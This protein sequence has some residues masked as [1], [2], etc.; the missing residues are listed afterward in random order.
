[1]RA[2]PEW[3]IHMAPNRNPLPRS[4]QHHNI[5]NTSQ[6]HQPHRTLPIPWHAN[7]LLRH[8]LAFLKSQ[9]I[10]NHGFVGHF[11]GRIAG[12]HDGVEPSRKSD[13]RALGAEGQ[14]AV[15]AVVV[16]GPR[17]TD[18]AEKRICDTSMNPRREISW[19]IRVD[20]V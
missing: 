19:G 8:R 12:A 1:M 7:L 4:D 2:S 11:V 10:F 15:F 20:R 9:G 13:D 18:T 5:P 17:N 16:A 3:A 14:Q 6:N